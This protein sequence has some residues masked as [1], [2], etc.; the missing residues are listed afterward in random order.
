MF[1]ATPTT[2]SSV[3]EFHQLDLIEGNNKTVKV[4]ERIAHK[5]EEVATRLYFGAHDIASIK[6]DCHYRTL[7]ASRQVMMEWQMGKGRKPTTWATLINALS[8][9]DLAEVSYDLESVIECQVSL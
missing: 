9:A 2:L 6:Q 1:I 8:E 3:P 5:W 4:I 7:Q